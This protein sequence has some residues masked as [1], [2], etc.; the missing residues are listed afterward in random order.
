MKVTVIGAS[1]FVGRH[2]IKALVARGDD[3]IAASVHRDVDGAAQACD[4]AD[5]VVNLAGESVSQRWTEASKRRMW[6]SRV[7][8]TRALVAR[9]AQ[10]DVPP[11]AYVSASAT[12]YYPASEAETYDESSPPGTDF[13]ARLC[14][15]W[16]AEAD[17]AASTETRVAKIRTGLVLGTDG[18]ALK[19]LLPIFRLGLGGRVGS[20]RQWFPWIHID[21]LVGVYVA[22]I[23]GVGGAL[24]GTAPNP[25]TNAEFTRALGSALHRP[26]IFPVPAFVPRLILG[27]GA[28]II[29]YGQRVLPERALANGYRFNFDTLDA[30]LADLIANR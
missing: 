14:V 3:V 20:G 12:G 5:A 6:E 17:R 1:G 7:D 26:A 15:A 23:D 24:N 29:L 25:V 21:D 30:A 19:G 13:L 11:K 28:D 22:A 9:F 10:L 2:L 18:G 27:E 8:R 16:E 4:G